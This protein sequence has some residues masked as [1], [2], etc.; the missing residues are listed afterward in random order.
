MDSL[1]LSLTPLV[2]GI[3]GNLEGERWLLSHLHYV[4]VTSARLPLHVQNV[5]SA[6]CFRSAHSLVL[7]RSPPNVF[8]YPRRLSVGDCQLLGLCLD[9]SGVIYIHCSVLRSL[10]KVANEVIRDGLEGLTQ[11]GQDLKAQRNA[12]WR[13]PLSNNAIGPPAVTTLHSP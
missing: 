7:Q 13:Q 1:A 12:S 5:C 9:Q 2:A 4:P 6:Q 3:R 8:Q 10:L 11:H